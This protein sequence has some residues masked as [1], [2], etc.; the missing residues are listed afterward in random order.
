MAVRL[1]KPSSNK[2]SD[3]LLRLE[4]VEQILSTYE[5]TIPDLNTTN[6]NTTISDLENKVDAIEKAIIQLIPKV[7]SFTQNGTSLCDAMLI[8]KQQLDTIVT[9]LKLR[10][11]M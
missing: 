9:I 11:L 4:R 2:N 1:S 8:L 10:G 7:E 5:K 3:I 6:N